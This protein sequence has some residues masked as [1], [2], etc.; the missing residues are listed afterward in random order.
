LTDD[1]IPIRGIRLGDLLSPYLFLIC[2]EGLSS[3]L[4]HVENIGGIDGVK[5][6]MGATSVS[7]LLFVDDSLTL[8]KAD[9]NNAISLRQ[10]LD[11]YCANSG[12]LVSVAKSSIFFSHNTHV[13]V[14]VQMCNTLNIDNEDLSDKY[15]GLPALVGIDRTVF[16]TWLKEL[17]NSLRDGRKNNYILVAKRS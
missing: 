6:C 17:Y 2:A 3:S 13:D 7:H 4:L 9:L 8:L 5:L 10:V 11:S 15:L 1:F 16:S 14:R 12:Q